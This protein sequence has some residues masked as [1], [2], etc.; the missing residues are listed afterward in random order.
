MIPDPSPSDEILRRFDAVA[1]YLA[2]LDQRFDDSNK[3]VEQAERRLVA[4]VDDIGTHV[5]TA[6]D[7]A[8]RLQATALAVAEIAQL[9]AAV[10]LGAAIRLW[11]W[12]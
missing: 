12:P 10:L 6:L 1:R 5:D 7:R 4:A 11:L 9:V 3:R 2:Y 8:T